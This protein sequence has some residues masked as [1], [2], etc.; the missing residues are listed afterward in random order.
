[1]GDDWIEFSSSKFYARQTIISL[2]LGKK[3]MDWIEFW[4][5]LDWKLELRIG[6]SG[7]QFRE[8]RLAV[9]PCSLARLEEH[10]MA[11]GCAIG[12]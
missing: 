4:I 3:S 8:S 11:L 5:G 2:W 6:I 12:S 10:V 7:L 1:M 9:I